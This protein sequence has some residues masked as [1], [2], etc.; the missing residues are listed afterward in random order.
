MS[1]FALF[2]TMADRSPLAKMTVTKRTIIIRYNSDSNVPYTDRLYF[3]FNI[4]KFRQN[5][6][7]GL[8]ENRKH[9]M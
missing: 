3:D 8:D 7:N 5:I 4:S 1:D 6:E 2:L 9:A